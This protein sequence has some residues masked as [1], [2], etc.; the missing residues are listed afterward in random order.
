MKARIFTCAALLFC[1]AAGGRADVITLNEG[2]RIQGQIERLSEGK[3]RIVTAFAGTLT[4]DVA[5]VAS[6]ETEEPVVVSMASGDR[7]VGTV[8]AMPDNGALMVETQMGGVPVAP[9]SLN[10]LWLPGDK[11]PEVLAVEAQRDK[12]AAEFKAKEPKWS[13][14]LEAGSVYRQ[15]NT[16]TFEARG[17]AEVKRKSDKDLLRFWAA[18]EYGEQNKERNV[19]EVRGGA[20][21]EYLFSKRLFG[22][23]NSELEYDEFE[24]LDLRM[25]LAFG[26]GY[27]WIKKTEHELKTRAGIGYIHE[28]FMDGVTND[29]M[30]MDI[31]V[32]YRLDLT[33]WLQYTHSTT[34]YPT[35]ESI[36]DYRL[37]MDN[38]FLIPLAQSD[39]WKLK[40]GALYEYDPIP[41]TGV[42]SLDETYYA[43][44]VMELK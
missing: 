12:L 22:Y 15:G 41:P 38:A 14:T 21:Y 24:N 9:E 25:Q 16:N 3:I 23:G 43:N 17:R 31:G 10:A 2:S 1:C 20:Y 33:P 26:G 37:V 6:I 35:F 19:A 29:R 4:V 34:Y 44:I 39:I 28:T 36:R 40:I 27:Y 5:M 42:E 32:D 18:G 7:L 11:S 8:H 30:Q 13:V